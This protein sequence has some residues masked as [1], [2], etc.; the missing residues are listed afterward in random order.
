MS[1]GEFSERGLT[2][3][4]IL[5]LLAII[6]I[7]VNIVAVGVAGISGGARSKAAATELQTVQLAFDTLT[8]EVGAITVSENLT[9]GGVTVS[10]STVITCYGQS[11]AVINV[12]ASGYYLRLR[13]PSN[14]RYTWDSEG[15]V[16]QASY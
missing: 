6:A 5:L 14:G 15:L 9:S 13:M 4:E 7:L 2:L 11:G 1:N 16:S 3:V 8:V 12:P 10:S